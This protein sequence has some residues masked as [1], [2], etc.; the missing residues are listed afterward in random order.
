MLTIT[1][2]PLLM[3]SRIFPCPTKKTAKIVW[4][5]ISFAG[6]FDLMMV[7]DEKSGDQVVM[8]IHPVSLHR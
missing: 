5:I 3:F 1:L 6:M 4:N 7:L 8:T 2:V